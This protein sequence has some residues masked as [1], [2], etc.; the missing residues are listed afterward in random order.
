MPTQ[1][2]VQNAG[3]RLLP[4]TFHSIFL[5]LPPLSA[6]FTQV[7][8]TAL[9]WNSAGYCSTQLLR[10]PLSKARLQQLAGMLEYTA[11]PLVAVQPVASVLLPSADVLSGGPL[12]QPALP[13]T[14]LH[15]WLVFLSAP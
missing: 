14:A 9:T 6:L 2:F 1:P 12:L 8:L 10:D 11:L 13:H 5:V 4:L 15:P 7:G 3:V